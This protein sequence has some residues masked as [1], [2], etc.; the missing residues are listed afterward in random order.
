MAD[1]PK[2][3]ELARLLRAELFGHALMM[4]TEEDDELCHSGT[5][6]EATEMIDK[7]DGVTKKPI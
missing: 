2:L 7:R 3:G 5:D 6:D 1:K 4:V